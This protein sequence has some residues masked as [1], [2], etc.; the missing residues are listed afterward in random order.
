MT[1]LASMLLLQLL[2]LLH[3]LVV[4]SIHRRCRH[5][6]IGV[7]VGCRGCKTVHSSIVINMAIAITIMLLSCSRSHS[8]CFVVRFNQLQRALGKQLGE[9]RL[10]FVARCY[11]RYL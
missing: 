11:Q 6:G 8:L 10:R 1:L 2:Y 9:Q 3:L 7:G 4:V 5:C